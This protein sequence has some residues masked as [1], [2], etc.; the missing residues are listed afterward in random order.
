MANLWKKA[1]ASLLTAALLSGGAPGLSASAGA[2]VVSEA[3]SASALA[4]DTAETAGEISVS[5]K[6]S[7]LLI[8]GKGG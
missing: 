6:G 8:S 4:K 2:P 5:R 7:L 1:T 3:V